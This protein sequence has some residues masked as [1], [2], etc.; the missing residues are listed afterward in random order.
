MQ[1]IQDQGWRHNAFFMTVVANFYPFKE[2]NKI[3]FMYS[4]S[5]QP[6]R[7]LALHLVN[8][9]IRSRTLYPGKPKYK[10]RTAFPINQTIFE[11]K[12]TSGRC[13]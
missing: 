4:F 2:R 13:I 11:K 10:K 7:S 12:K 6:E 1:L 5:E 9:Y 3:K 8:P